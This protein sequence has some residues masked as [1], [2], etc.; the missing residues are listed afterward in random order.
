MAP[1]DLSANARKSDNT[2][3][4]VSFL[5][6]IFGDNFLSQVLSGRIASPFL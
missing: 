5:T 1:F 4:S 2:R 6:V 3:R